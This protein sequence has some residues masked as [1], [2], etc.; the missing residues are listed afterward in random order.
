MLCGGVHRVW[1]FLRVAILD[2]QHHLA[3]L[4]LGQVHLV[5]LLLQKIFQVLDLKFNSYHEYTL[6]AVCSFERFHMV[7]NFHENMFSTGLM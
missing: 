1:V 5:V 2:L 7:I 3:Q 4:R 6:L